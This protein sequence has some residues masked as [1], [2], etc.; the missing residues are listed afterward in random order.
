MELT[1]GALP[2]GH[3]SRQSLL[4]FRFQE[5]TNVDRIFNFHVLVKLPISIFFFKK[6]LLVLLSRSLKLKLEWCSKEKPNEP[7]VYEMIVRMVAESPAQETF[8]RIATGDNEYGGRGNDT[9]ELVG[10]RL[11]GNSKCL[12]CCYDAVRF[13]QVFP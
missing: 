8:L 12:E 11:E 3:K 1:L 6:G 13:P 7:V 2:V 10:Q 9:I 5:T 4:K